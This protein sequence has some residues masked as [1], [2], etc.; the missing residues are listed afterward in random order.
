M[1][2]QCT[3]Y[4]GIN[5]NDLLYFNFAFGSSWLFFV[6]AEDITNDVATFNNLVKTLKP[7]NKDRDRVDLMNCFRDIIQ[8]YTNAKQW[9]KLPNSTHFHCN[10]FSINSWPFCRLIYD[11]N[12]INQYLLFTFFSWSM[13]L[14]SNLLMTLEFQLV[15]YTLNMK[16]VHWISFSK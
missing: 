11:F 5:I 10:L 1:D 8:N 6:I 2:R 12:E 7:K 4:A 3:A 16:I 15:E 14:V 9:V 13:L